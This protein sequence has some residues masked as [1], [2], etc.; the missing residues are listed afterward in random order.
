MFKWPKTVVLA[1]DRAAI[2][3]GNWIS[4]LVIIQGI[5]LQVLKQ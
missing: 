2:E 5:I 4:N 3:T 1:L